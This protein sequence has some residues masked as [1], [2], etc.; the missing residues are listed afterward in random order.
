MHS[1]IWIPFPS[2]H[3]PFPSELVQEQPGYGKRLFLYG[4]VLHFKQSD[5]S[6]V[7]ARHQGNWGLP[8]QFGTIF[9]FCRIYFLTRWPR[10][11]YNPVPM[12]AQ[13]LLGCTAV[14]FS[15]VVSLI[16]RAWGW[17][18]ISPSTWDQSRRGCSLGSWLPPTTFCR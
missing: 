2:C 18:T 6:V 4:F 11:C 10:N 3:H 15:N 5:Q 17:E 1:N 12:N 9:L 16:N 14:V 8:F 7:Q 13:S